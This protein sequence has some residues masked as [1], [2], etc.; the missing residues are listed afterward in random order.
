M[1]DSTRPHERLRKIQ[2]EPEAERSK[3]VNS[4]SGGGWQRWP[5]WLFW[6]GLLIVTAGAAGDVLHHTLPGDLA[7]S[8]SPLLGS[9]GGRAHLVTLLGMVLTVIGL[10]VHA[11]DRR[12]PRPD[13]VI[14]DE[15]ARG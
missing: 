3:C 12:P 11:G 9:D 5:A 6:I 2:P 15:S 1:L 13:P 7:G 10:G 14:D 4:R 8:L